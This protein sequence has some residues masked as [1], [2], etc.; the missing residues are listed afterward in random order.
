MHGC[1]IE[2]KISL[3]DINDS[4]NGSGGQSSSTRDLVANLNI[5]IQIKPSEYYIR[6][7]AIIIY[8]YV[9]LTR[10]YFEDVEGSQ[11]ATEGTDLI[12]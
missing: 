3:V 9:H 2:R 4:N 5:N 8:A 1:I 10:K 12:T 6:K 7:I 11:R